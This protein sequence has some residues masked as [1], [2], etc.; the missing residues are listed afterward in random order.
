[1]SAR[2]GRDLAE[3]LGDQVPRELMDQVMGSLTGLGLLM[4]QPAGHFNW[5]PTGLGE[6]LADVLG[7][8]GRSI[9]QL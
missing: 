4:P 2:G 7:D 1:M 5:L 9:E 8:P 6:R 3:V